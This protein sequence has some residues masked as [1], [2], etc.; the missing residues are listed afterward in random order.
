VRYAFLLSSLL[1]SLLS[2]GGSIP[3]QV[4]EVHGGTST[5]YDSQGG[6]IEIKGNT[7]DAS[8]GAGT[9]SSRFMGGAA[10]TK[11][12]ESTTLTLGSEVI[13]FNLPTD[14]FDSTHFLTALGGSLRAKRPD[15]DLLVFGGMMAELFNGPFFQSAQGKEPAAIMI[16]DGKVSPSVS[17]A[18]RMI[19]S[20]Q[21]TLIE[22]FGWRPAAWAQLAASGGI[23]AGTPYAAVS[24]KLHYS[25]FD[26]KTAYIQTSSNF[27]RA[28]TDTVLSSEPTRLNAVLTFAP[29]DKGYSVTAGHTSYLTPVAGSPNDIR[30][31]VDELEGNATL[32]R[33]VLSASI[34]RSTYDG[35][36]NSAVILSSSRP[37]GPRLRLQGSYLYSSN[38]QGLTTSSVV[39]NITETLTP[40]WTISQI[41]NSANGQTSIGFGTNFLSNIATLDA[42]YQTYYV[43]QHLPNPFEQV[44]IVNADLNLLGHGTIHGGTFVAPDGSAQRTIAADSVFVRNGP[45]IRAN[46]GNPMGR[47][48]ISGQVL[49]TSHHP[50]EGAA[51]LIDMVPVYTDS[52]GNF[53]LR[54][55]QSHPHS[56]QVQGKRFLDGNEYM[57]VSAAHNIRSALPEA[58]ATT[59]I[60]VEKMPPAPKP[61]P[62]NSPPNAPPNSAPNS[63]CA[64]GVV[65]K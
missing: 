13:P 4:I 16:F 53:Q 29:D 2:L 9:T 28:A 33:M 35:G 19:L 1:V 44:L 3:A 32:K 20:Q 30:S 38:S 62:P 40:K 47:F 11:H 24:A 43:P 42:E 34:F 58:G 49:D 26:L 37:F 50:V 61:P 23:G 59:T 65:C 5:L 39:T 22:G 6:A 18:S 51:L 27:R 64:P 48:V 45:P 12:F 54:E 63:K 17:I 57:V 52:D 21:I 36:G 55:P 60:I 14:I 46:E 25:A 7:Y 41:V 8:L 31:S 10:L 56:L 15:S